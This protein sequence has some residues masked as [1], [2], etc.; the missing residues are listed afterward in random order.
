MCILLATREHPDYDLILVSNRDEFFERRTNSA[1]WHN[2]DSILSPF[3]MTNGLTDIEHEIYSTWIGVN[4]SSKLCSILNLKLLDDNISKSKNPLKTASRGLLPFTFLNNDK[5]NVD[6]YESFDKLDKIYPYLQRSGDFN[7]FYGDI[8]KQKYIVIDALGNT[9]NVLDNEN[10][11]NAVVSNDIYKNF[12]DNDIN[13]WGKI[14]LGKLKLIELIENTKGMNERQLTE[15]CFKMASICSIDPNLDELYKN[16]FLMA[17]T[18]FVPP[19]P[20]LPQQDVGLTITGGLY[21]GTRSQMVLLV[22]KNRKN[23]TVCER[24]LHT[25][26]KDINLF[27]PHHPK[28]VKFFSFSI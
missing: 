22:D 1:C 26:D 19:L 2:N 7:F 17:Q 24:I 4:R 8:K 12:K 25:S 13:E 15:Y 28:E 23:V 16:P 20:Y 11:L 14:K 3:D 18:I 10:G 6:E 5:I 27:G 9:Y 21:F